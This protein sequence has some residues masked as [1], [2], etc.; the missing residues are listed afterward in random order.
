M[1]VCLVWG[2]CVCARARA[3]NHGINHYRSPVS[4][5]NRLAL[6]LGYKHKTE[7]SILRSFRKAQLV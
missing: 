5:R 1:R 6:L 4:Q 2:V 3:N 7:N